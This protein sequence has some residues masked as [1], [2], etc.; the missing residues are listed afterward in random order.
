MRKVTRKTLD[1][2]YALAGFVKIGSWNG[3]NMTPNEPVVVCSHSMV[4]LCFP[5]GYLILTESIDDARTMC[6]DLGLRKEPYWWSLVK[7]YESKAQA[8]KCVAEVLRFLGPCGRPLVHL[9]QNSKGQ[10]QVTYD[11][12][13]SS[14]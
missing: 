12:F 9:A 4:A 6:A 13:I 10:W 1:I 7:T 11:G 2:L 3:R 14:L 8:E 5:D